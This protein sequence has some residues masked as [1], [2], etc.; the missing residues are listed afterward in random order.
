MPWHVI[1]NHPECGGRFAVVAD[2]TDEL[3]SCHDSRADADKTVADMYAEMGG[4]AMGGG[5]MGPKKGAG[6]Y[7]MA[8]AGDPK[9]PYGDVSYADP[10]YQSDGKKRYA[11]NTYKR[12]KAAWSYINHPDNA[13]KYTSEQLARI[14]S[15]IKAAGK[16][17]G[18]EFGD[19][20]VRAAAA[21]TLVGVELAR[22]GTW[23]LSSGKRTFT[24]QNLRDAA[25]FF[26]ATGNTRI[27]LGFGHTDNRFDG[28]PAW[29]WVDNIRYTEDDQGPV[30][31]G[32]L[33]D[34]DDWVAAAAPRR[35]PNRSVEGFANLSFRG[36]DYS[37]ALTR[38]ALLGAT[39]PAMPVL[40]SLAD[41]R[42]A[43]AAAA[44]DSHA[45][46]IAASALPELSEE[47]TP[48]T[49]AAEADATPIPKEARMPNVDPA[50]IREALDLADDASDEEVKTALVEAGLAP[51]VITPIA[52]SGASGESQQ[53]VDQ[54]I[55]AAAARGGVITID[56]ATVQQFQEGMVRASAL[57][58][59]L[60]EMDRDTVINAAVQEGKFPPS[61]REH[62]ARMW[63]A[64]PAGTRELIGTLSAGLVPVT[65]SGYADV[66]DDDVLWETEFSRLFP[67]AATATKGS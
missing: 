59:R 15:R 60:D 1:P 64:D 38:V 49:P 61:R 28:D 54:R 27:P 57:A 12:C 37:L 23:H 40:R 2:D 8:A 41:L 20:E 53:A 6:G 66:T 10:G 47:D 48:E 19:D 32:D 51:P 31:L 58:R 22:P 11:L 63:A 39:P 16:R 46:P 35:W 52:A 45:E 43:V 13:G 5:G 62:Y 36:R 14:K 21:T 65:A 42:A 17:F 24:E 50:L 56:A 3:M 29:G 18:I 26:T 30:L 33:V 55:A 7:M 67:P 4:E 34:V 25:D 9:K 44:A